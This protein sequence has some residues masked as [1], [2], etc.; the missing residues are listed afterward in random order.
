M[1]QDLGLWGE[2]SSALEGFLV[3]SCEMQFFDRGIIVSF[4]WEGAIWAK[5]RKRQ[6]SYP[7]EPVGELAVWISAVTES[8]EWSSRLRKQVCLGNRKK[9]E[10]QSI[11]STGKCMYDWGKEGMTWGHPENFAFYADQMESLSKGVIWPDLFL[12]DHIS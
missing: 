8:L 6:K 3:G 7:R 1:T 4:Q 9:P 12:K 5:R 11:V 2:S 10:W